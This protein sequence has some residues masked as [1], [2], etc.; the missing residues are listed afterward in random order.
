MPLIRKAGN[1]APLQVLKHKAFPFL[2]RSL[3]ARHVVFICGLTWH[4]ISKGIF[5][6]TC[7]PSRVPKCLPCDSG[8]SKS[9]DH[10]TPAA[11]LV[12]CTHTGGK[13]RARHFPS[14]G[15]TTPIRYFLTHRVVVKSK[16]TDVYK[17]LRTIHR[18]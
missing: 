18:A 13:G 10:Q 6:G 12:H 16:E 1:K 5:G 15:P 8:H 14:Q 2:P 17:T 4:S 7:R 11:C 9:R 3:L